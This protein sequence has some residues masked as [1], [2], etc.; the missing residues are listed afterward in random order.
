MIIIFGLLRRVAVSL[1]LGGPFVA[2]GV[3]GFMEP[4]FPGWAATVILLVGA[5]LGSF[6]LYM[7]IAGVIPSPN[8]VEGEQLLVT[9]HPTMK[10]AFARLIMSVPFF[11]AAGYLFEWTQAPYPTSTHSPY[12]SWGC[13]CS[14]RERCGICATSTSPTRSPTAG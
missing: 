5:T 2:A 10:P 3:L 4:D 12:S 1:V 14:S 13:T 6:G 11:L 8:L 9:R 7:S